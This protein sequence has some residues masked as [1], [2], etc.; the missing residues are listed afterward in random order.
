[1]FGGV[2]G[3]D[4]E[5]KEQK[6]AARG[7]ELE[8]QQLQAK[9]AQMELEQ[10]QEKAKQQEEENA[11]LQAKVKELELVQERERVRKL[12]EEHKAMQEKIATLSK[13]KKASEAFD[14]FGDAGDGDGS[15]T[16]VSTGVGEPEPSA[17]KS[18]RSASK[19]SSQ[20]KS[21]PNTEKESAQV[22]EPEVTQESFDGFEQIPICAY[23]SDRGD[24]K[25]TVK[26]QSAGAT[27]LYCLSHACGQPGCTQSK[28]SR[29]KHCKEHAS[30]LSA[31]TPTLSSTEKS[32]T[33]KSKRASVVSESFDGF[34]GENDA[35]EKPVVT[36]QP[37]GEESPKKSKSTSR[38]ANIKAAAVE[39]AS[40]VA[41]KASAAKTAA[42]E[43]GKDALAKR[44]ASQEENRIKKEEKAQLAAENKALAE[45]EQR[46]QL[47]A[48]IAAGNAVKKARE[49]RA[50]AAKMCFCKGHKHKMECFEHGDTGSGDRAEDWKCR[51]CNNPKSKLAPHHWC[52]QCSMG[53]CVDCADAKMKEAAMYQYIVLVDIKDNK[54]L[55]ELAFEDGED[56]F[57]EYKSPADAFKE[58]FEDVKE[59]QL[60]NT[61]RL[62]T[63]LAS[64]FTLLDYKIASLFKMAPKSE[65][66]MC[67]AP[68]TYRCRGSEP[69]HVSNPE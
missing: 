23:T 34:A 17:K 40:A 52:S 19:K 45:Q 42:V 62:L 54:E 6:D 59:A 64:E 37:A 36:T 50:V 15:A 57:E 68:S 56:D 55:F 1:M 58:L 33:K 13:P 5:L 8:N 27:S 16:A 38:F 14:G 31:D 3:V 24:C 69:K 63:V 29:A 60:A 7:K 12:E 18:N 25:K 2:L 21:K 28:S 49:D 48:L 43:K 4:L 22:V 61:G 35:A 53:Y 32:N 47:E 39:K 46:E 20:Q 26:A 9:I 41:K 65:F 67:F 44:R 51:G 66:E 11:R 10:E 30:Q